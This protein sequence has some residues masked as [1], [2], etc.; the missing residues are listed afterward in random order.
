MRLAALLAVALLTAGCTGLS[1][2]AA[3]STVHHL[4][5]RTYLLYVPDGLPAQAPLVVMLHGGFGSAAQAERAYGWDRLADT[6]KFAVAYPDGLGRAWNAG[7]GCCGRSAA[8]GVDD[9]GFIAAAVSDIARQVDVDPKRVYATGISNGGMMTYA[10]ACHTT[11]FAAIGPDSA[12][13]LDPCPAPRP[14]SVLHIH[15]TADTRIRYDGGR[16]EGFAHI[17][18]PSVPAVNTFWR[19]VDQCAA[20]AVTVDGSVTTSAA[21]CADGRAVT[22]MTVDGGGHEWPGFAT[23]RLWQFFAAHPAK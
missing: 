3:G 20:P 13:Q 2:A 21:E 9:V 10:L 14:T 16:G 17:D 1:A 18:G 11:L 5:D 7:G 22:L 19:N 12:T 6:A 23:D 8:D 15:G 4:G